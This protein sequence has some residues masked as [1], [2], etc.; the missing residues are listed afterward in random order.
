VILL[1]ANSTLEVVTAN[2]VTTD[3]TASYADLTSS[4]FVPGGSEANPTAATTT[5]VAAPA[6]GVR[7]VKGVSIRNT[8]ATTDQI[9]TVQKN[10]SATIYNVI[11]VT[12][13]PLDCLHYESESCAWTIYDYRG[14]VRAAR[15][16]NEPGPGFRHRVGFS[17]GTAGSTKS[18]TTQTAFAYYVGKA[19]AGGITAVQVRVRVTT[20]CSTITY[21]EFAIATGA[22]VIGGNPTLMVV[23]YQDV[24]AI[25]NQ[26]GVRTVLIPVSS[27]QKILEGD[28]LWVVV[29]NQATT[30]CVLRADNEADDLQS[31][32]AAAAT[33]T[34]PSTIVGTPT[35]FTT[36][37]ATVL[38]PWMAVGM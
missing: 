20:G 17:T 29:G 15:Y 11:S 18:L 1:D 30:A 4:T 26:T 6:S 21:A 37:G 32:Y 13:R 25:I 22:P 27:G 28:D 33:T 9:V 8:S 2:A 10:V 3:M 24:S 23:G 12:L 19:S 31:G 5:L 16:P 38:A 36:E 35:A 14:D 7:Q 34:Q